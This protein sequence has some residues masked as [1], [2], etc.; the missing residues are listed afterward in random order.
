MGYS[1]VIPS[2]KRV[3]LLQRALAS[4]Y[5][6]SLV[7]S[8]VHLVIDEPEDFDKYAFLNKHD[9]SLRVTFTGGG[10]GGAKA[11]NVGLDQVDAD[12]VFFLDDDDEW[13]PEKAEK[14]IELLESRPDAVGVTCQY[15]KGNDAGKELIARSEDLV[16]RCVKIWNYSGGFSC[17]GMRWSGELTL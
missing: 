8:S 16:N 1:V 12:F 9:D 3:E 14:Q 17:F 2:Y 6:Q 4:V 15:W 5:A 10:F 11:R 13:L 7:P